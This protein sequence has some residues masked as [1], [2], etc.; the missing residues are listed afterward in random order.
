[1]AM[2]KEERRNFQKKQARLHV[3]SGVPT[4]EELTEGIPV[5][6]VTDEGLVQYINY[7]GILYKSIYTK[8]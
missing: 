4:V 1:M 8:A 3:K 2:S 5:I 7:N 6:R